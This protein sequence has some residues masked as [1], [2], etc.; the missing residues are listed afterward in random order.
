MFERNIKMLRGEAADWLG[1]PGPE[2]QDR[3]DF[4]GLL[5][6]T[7]TLVAREANDPETPMGANKAGPQKPAISSQR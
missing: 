1:T 3:G 5:C 6:P 4:L 7:D 2:D